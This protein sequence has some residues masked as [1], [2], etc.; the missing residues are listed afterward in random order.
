MVVTGEGWTDLG[1][2]L[3]GRASPGTGVRV[4]RAGCRLSPRVAWTSVLL[5]AGW[6]GRSAGLTCGGT[7]RPA[8]TANMGW[9]A[10]PCGHPGR[11]RGGQDALARDEVWCLVVVPWLFK[12]PRQTLLDAQ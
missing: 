6:V 11:K 5:S 10:P 1:L 2:W 7:D 12:L 3:E 8:V 4:V 9:S